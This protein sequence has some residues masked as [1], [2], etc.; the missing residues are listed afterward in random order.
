MSTK[1]I[2]I[3]NSR[4]QNLKTWIKNGAD[5]DIAIVLCH[6]F[7]WNSD[8][9]IK[10]LA[11]YFGDKYMACRFDFSWQWQSGW[12][13]VDS[14]IDD[15][16][17][18]LGSV[19]DYLRKNYEIKKLILLWHS[20]WVA[21]TTIYWW[22]N[23]IDWFISL[24]WEWNLWNA[25]SLE[26]NEDQL[27]DFREKW[28]A[29]YENWSKGWEM[30]TLWV[31]FLNGM[32]KYS[33]NS[34]VSNIKCPWLFIHWT[35]DVVIPFGQTLEAFELYNW[36]KELFLMDWGDHS[37]WFY[38]WNNRSWEIIDIIENWIYKV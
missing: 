7:S 24:S 18:D 30:D 21:I 36:K 19:V 10:D 12:D 8:F 38:F 13:F 2:F 32:M 14:S 3:K 6:W 22:D 31:Q 5:S 23:D 33:D 15:E 27:N 4:W 17:D 20:F 25:I 29:L 35:N 26:F 9:L 37:Y 28:T 1:E 11:E 16:L 34:H